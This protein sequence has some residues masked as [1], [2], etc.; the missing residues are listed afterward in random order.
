MDKAKWH[1]HTRSTAPQLPGSTSSWAGSAIG[2]WHFLGISDLRHR[3]ARSKLGQLWLVL[4]TAAMIGVLTAVYSLLFNQRIQVLMPF[5][6]VSLIM[7]NYLSQVLIECSS[8][9]AHQGGS[10]PN[11]VNSAKLMQDPA[12]RDRFDELQRSE[13]R[14]VGKECRL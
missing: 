11:A 5:I 13:E 12:V 8:I 7:W 4:S 10:Y 3:Y 1:C 9:F 2:G 6:G 14:R